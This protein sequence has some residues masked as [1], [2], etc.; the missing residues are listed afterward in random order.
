VKMTIRIVLLIL[1]LLGSCVIGQAQTAKIDQQGAAFYD[2]VLRSYSVHSAFIAIDVQSKEYTGRT[3]I[4]NAHL[5]YFFN[6]IRGYDISDY[7]A[8]MKEKLLNKDRISLG[9]VSLKKWGFFKVSAIKAVETHASNGLEKFIGHYFQ[10]KVIKD[11]VGEAERN[12]VIS[13]LF[14][15]GVVAGIDDETGYLV[16]SM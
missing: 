4:E 11:G 6:Q 13:K 3:V 9:N 7:M 5:Y 1:T 14:E 8:F 10:G 15:F 12:A 2:K 16:I